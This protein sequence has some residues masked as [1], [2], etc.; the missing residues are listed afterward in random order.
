[1]AAARI[2]VAQEIFRDVFF[3][4]CSPKLLA[5]HKRPIRRVADLL[6]LPLIHFDWMSRD[7]AGTAPSLF[8]DLA[9]RTFQAEGPR[10]RASDLAGLR[11]TAHR[12]TPPLTTE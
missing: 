5:R 12:R 9:N 2:L 7:R 4:V 3:P 6:R 8:C 10:L 11:L 1:L